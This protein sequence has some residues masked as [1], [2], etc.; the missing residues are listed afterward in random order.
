MSSKT[1][2]DRLRRLISHGYFAPE[3]PP[4]FVSDDLAKY[5]KFILKGIDALP[6]TKNGG[7]PPKLSF[8]SEPAWFYYPRFGRDDRRHGVPNPISHILLSNEIAENYV[9]LK[10]ISKK[11]KISTSPPVFDWSGQRA[12]LRP[13]IDLRDDFRIDLSSRREEFVS[14][15]I[16]AFFHSIYT[17]SIPWAIYGK[18]WSKKN[19]SYSH[20]GNLI[21][22]YC[23]NSQDGQTIGLPVGPDTSRLLAE[24]IASAIDVEICAALSIDERDASR[25]IDDYTISS[26]DNLTG[27]SIVAKLRQEA[28][29]FELEL[30]REK[31]Q[32]ISTSTRQDSGWK[33]A[34]RAHIPRSQ[35]PTDSEIQ[36]YFY[37]IGGVCSS[38]PDIN[39]EKFA[40]QNARISLLQASNWKKVQNLLINGYRRNPSLISILVELTLL[41]KI[42]NN[43][44]D[45]DQIKQFI[46]SRI[47]N[48]AESNRT[49]ELIW[50][51]FCAIRLRVTLSAKKLQPLF[52]IENSF[53]ATLVV[54]ADHIG[55]INGNVNKETW[56]SS[57][58][59]DG[60]QGGM[61]L[62][63]YET[64]SSGLNNGASISFISSDPFFGLL[65][66]K[67]VR[68]LDMTAGFQSTSRVLSSLRK[69]N[70]K[71]QIIRDDFEDDF[72][73]EISEFDD[74]FDDD[75]YY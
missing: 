3:L 70:K 23:R 61:W 27:E 24:I 60:L 74:E 14:T 42:S 65:H 7:K 46:E 22:L 10:A 69:N 33:D 4:C 64:V 32:I 11:S 67:S 17:H 38:H 73:I 25:Y 47:E 15:D 39:V 26:Q 9:K 13:S 50:L 1:K 30:S 6:P 58:T 18:S 57:L 56:D 68:F 5:R 36:R 53:I 16:R 59:T 29:K 71:L 35:S 34:V 37:E 51:L 48:L 31:T 66:S 12:L 54:A 49:G 62:Y 41:R 2:S 72:G 28:S 8:T 19:R 20:Y 45:I 63:A 40:Y 43:D 21:D 75:T 44:V 52:K 55:L